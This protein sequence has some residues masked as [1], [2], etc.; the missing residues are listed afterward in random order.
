MSDNIL[1]ATYLNYMRI[2]K[3]KSWSKIMVKCNFF[4]FIK[5]LRPFQFYL[6]FLGIKDKQ[7][8]I[9]YESEK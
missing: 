4:L 7:A 5:F 2:D 8:F 6:L 9:Y 3:G 1:P